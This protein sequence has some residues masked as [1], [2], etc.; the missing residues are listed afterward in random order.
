M[1]DSNAP[2]NYSMKGAQLGITEV[3]INRAFYTLD[4]RRRDV[5]YV[6]PTTGTAQDF[7]RTRFAPAL[8]MSPYLKNLFTDTNTVSLK[9]AGTTNLYIRGSRGG[10]NLVSIPASLL[11]LDE[12][13]RMEQEK[14][15][16]AL[17]RL[18][19]QLTKEVWGISTPTLPNYGIHKIFQT[20]TQ[21]EY[22]FKCPSC[23]RHISLRWPDNFVV[24][25]DDLTDPRTDES[26]IKCNKCDAKLD[27]NSKPE[28]LE[29]AHW[30]PQN[31]SVRQDRR[32][33][34][35]N[36]L[37]SFTV[38]PGDIAVAHFRGFGSELAKKEFFNSKIGIPYIGDGAK[39]T[40]KHLSNCMGN[41]SSSQALLETHDRLVTMGIDQGKWGH[42]VVKEWDIS[43]YSQDLNAQAKARTLW[44]GKVYLNDWKALDQFMYD[45]HVHACVIDSQPEINEAKRFARRFPGHVWLCQYRKGQ[46]R[47][48]IAESED[49]G[50]AV[51][52][53]DRSQW[54]S[55]TLGRYKAKTPTITLPH[56]IPDEFQEHLQNVVGTY[57]EGDDGNP[58][59]TFIKTGADHY[60]HADNYS[61]MAL[62]LAASIMTNQDIK[63]FL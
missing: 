1:L 48:D 51:I 42:I 43:D 20:T 38:T 9:Q 45:W 7:S 46:I 58:K 53:V 39:V 8:E 13:D 31:T 34:H 24:C 6:L 27:H 4:I 49:D 21:E 55:A 54:L 10:A 41:Y 40:A 47:K 62:P 22:F 11:I 18:S 25:G 36:Q 44:A 50:A 16:L 28:F 32:G 52:T 15:W 14:I 35:I 12:V 26:Y 33:F 29:H 56:D 37:Y 57:V 61:E 30:V 60:T 19:G 59:L 23:S 5:L 2:F 63:N 3:V 17:E